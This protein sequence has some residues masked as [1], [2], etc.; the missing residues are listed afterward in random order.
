MRG[1]GMKFAGGLLA[2]GSAFIFLVNFTSYKNA[3]AMHDQLTEVY[4]NPNARVASGKQG[5]KVL[6]A[7]EVHKKQM[8]LD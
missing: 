2:A 6:A 1:S 4:N 5:K 8:E 7:L 3:L